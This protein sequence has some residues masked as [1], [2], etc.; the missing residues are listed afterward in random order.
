MQTTGDLSDHIA[1][2]YDESL[3]IRFGLFPGGVVD[4]ATGPD[5]YLYVLT[6]SGKVYKIEP[7]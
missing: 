6:F 3:H 5:G 4:I 2:N 1:D 7:V